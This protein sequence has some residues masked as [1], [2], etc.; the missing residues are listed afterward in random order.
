MKNFEA[1]G[2]SKPLADWTYEEIVALADKEPLQPTGGCH[3]VKGPLKMLQEEMQ[4]RGA[5]IVGDLG[6]VAVA[7][8]GVRLRLST[9]GEALS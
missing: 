9:V 5:K 8:Y 4:W 6:A 3:P 2:K 7:D 1:G